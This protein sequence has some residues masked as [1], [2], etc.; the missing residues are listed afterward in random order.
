MSVFYD[1]PAIA[2]NKENISEK[3][4]LSKWRSMSYETKLGTGTMLVAAQEARPEN[5]ELELD[6]EGW[7][8][9]Y[10]CQIDFGTDHYTYAKLTDD[11]CFA[12]LRT[13]PQGNPKVWMT[14]EYMQEYYW[15]SADLTGQRLII[16]KPETNGNPASNLVW[17]RCEKM[18]EAEIEAYN[19]EKNRC[20]QGHIDIDPFI[21]EEYKT[22]DD[23]LMKIYAL[24]NSNVD[25]CNIETYPFGDQI[26]DDSYVPLSSFLPKKWNGYNFE[27]KKLLTRYVEYG[28]KY[29]MKMYSSVRMSPANF[30][31]SGGIPFYSKNFFADNKQYYCK[32]RDGRTIKACSFAYPEVRDYMLNSLKLGLECGFDGISLIFTRGIHIGFEQPVIDRFRELYPDVDPITL[33]VSDERLHGVWCEFMTD[34]VKRVR[35]LIGSNIRLNVITDYGLATSKHLGLDVEEW[36]RLG[37]IDAATQHDMEIYEDLDGCLKDDG[38][39]DMDKYNAKTLDTEIVKRNFATNVEKVLGYAKEYLALEKYGVEVYNVLPW[40]NTQTLD[41]YKKVVAQMQNAGVKKF[42]C[43]NT[44]HLAWNLPEY[45]TIRSINNDNIKV[46]DLLTYY[47]TLMLDGND[48]SGF[49]PNWKG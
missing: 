35:E 16:R 13:P 25:I 48:I 9:I 32:N 23:T 12:G 8:R 36:A 1:L 40:A 39:I 3:F 29:G 47:R 41:Y 14:Y 31:L 42:H 2:V 6:L 43:W 46:D 30:V 26:Q 20:V 33:P 7:H 37:L 38:T 18:D 24:K 11:L 44:N 4:E 34:F 21:T 27:P 22:Y 17:I 28:H 19:G 5:I 49:N 10:L 45:N 15:K